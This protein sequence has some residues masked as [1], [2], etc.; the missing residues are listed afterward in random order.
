MGITSGQARCLI[1][2][3]ARRSAFIFRSISGQ[4]SRKFFFTETSHS[5]AKWLGD[6]ANVGTIEAVFFR[7]R[8]RPPI[9]AEKDEN[10]TRRET[11]Q[12]PPPSNADGERAAGEIGPED[13]LSYAL[14]AA[15]SDA[16]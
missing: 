9:V 14:E 8:P 15:R 12:A 7:E 4:T 11:A 1:Q 5:Y 2:P 16:R 10:R 6:T 3:T 13:E